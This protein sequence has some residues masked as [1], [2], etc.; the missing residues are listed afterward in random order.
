[1]G[2]PEPATLPV[3]IRV[4]PEPQ[5]REEKK[6]RRA[7]LGRWSIPT[8]W[9]VVDTETRIDA[10][11]RLTFGSYRFLVDGACL[12]EG[13]FYADDLPQ[14]DR[15][16]LEHYVRTHPADTVRTGVPELKLLSRRE[17]LRKFYKAAY[18][19]RC[20]VIGFNL[21]FDVSR[22][23]FAVSDARRRFTGGFSLSL[24]D[25]RGADG[26]ATIFRP[27]IDIKQIDSKR[28]L[29]GFTSHA[30]VEDDDRI[31]EGSASGKPVKDYVFRGNFLDLRTLAFA[32]TDR[33]HSLESACETFGVEH[34][35]VKAAQHGVVTPDYIDYNRRDVLATAE[36]ADKLIRE[37]ERHPIDLQVTKA[38]SAA[39]IGKA[40]LRAMGIA[41]V[42]ERQPHF[43]KRY[44]GFAQTA[45]FGG[46]ASAHIR[47]VPVPVVYVDF[48]SMY[49]TVNSLMRLG[50]M[51]T[52]PKVRVRECAAE[53]TEFLA[54][55]SKERLFVPKTWTELSA[56][57]RIVTDGDIL[58]TRS[59]YSRKSN[60]W[61]V[62]VN[63][64][65]ARDDSP[66][67]WFALPDLVASVLLTGRV[68]KIVEAFRIE[69]EGTL[70]TLRPIQFRGMV[71]IDPRQQDFFKTI[72]EERKR[73][74]RRK[75][76]PKLERD[77]L[78]KAAK[79]TGSAT[80]YG[81]FAQM[82]RHEESQKV[83]VT[84]YGLDPE[85][86]TCSV[87]HPES[88]GDFCFPPV[89]S[90]IT[91]GARLMLA[92]LER[93][94]RDLGGT[95]AMEDTDSMAIVASE[96]GGLVPCPGGPFCLDDGREAIKALRWSDVS[97]IAKQFRKLNPYDRK[98]VRGS[99]LKIEDDNF[100]PVTGKQRQV[101]CLA[102]SAKRY[103][104]FLRDDK[105]EPQLLR[106]GLN[107]AEDRWS[108][109]GLGHL[110]NPTDPESEDREWIAK[111]WLAIVRRAL[112]L[113]TKPLGFES[114]PAVGRISVSSPHVREALKTLNGGRPYS[115][116]IK[117]FNF[118]L[119]CH[120]K[121]LGHPI[122]VDPERFH[123]IG[124]YD[125][126]PKN[127]LKSKWIDQYSNPPRTYRITTASRYGMR[128]IARV[129]TYGDVLREYEYHA[130]AKYAAPNGLPSTKQTIG[131]LQRRHVRVG[132]I[133]PI[134]KESNSLE[135]VEAGHEHD[136]AKVYTEYP[137][138]RYDHWEMAVLPAMKQASLKDLVA[139]TGRS[140][141]MLKAARAGR[142]PHPKNMRLV[143]EALRRLHLL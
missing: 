124:P 121:A 104:L 139:E 110:L 29:I 140:P 119:S 115:E 92:L 116:Q 46:R 9:F 53:V 11:Q 31:P 114:R 130:E 117:P 71:T 127:W 123:L 44:L 27:R 49:T 109:H 12:E 141:A 87:K 100:D 24:W 26:R 60:D 97:A 15:R 19:G 51:V 88:P 63:H 94:V 64:L 20:L 36:L 70:D 48:V 28:S 83:P 105:G 66:D 4:Y 18:R 137:D 5:L 133:T 69:P 22:L 21:P 3:A 99:I 42:L 112:G 106:R 37:Y 125:P 78:D 33:G 128:G 134:G 107:N 76:L 25:R 8:A 61:Q 90:L 68:P 122:G 43:P 40:Y 62:A 118:L 2:A 101:W 85:P 93:S 74:A 136:P 23:A 52:V 45:F 143:A 57:A 120:V 79:T 113:P 47:K 103:A 17:F 102:I 108:E 38:Y 67:L 6:E 77:R 50:G 96:G 142:R 95:F 30:A 1:M 32:L 56:F 98:A 91:A 82:D 55:V 84:C 80:S 59:K 135:D 72:I 54:R 138:P 65:H 126:N 10:T 131:L 13:L 132:Q 129:K 75:D 41:P 81:I 39:S 89:A 35:K 111:A 14:D 7:R 58:P 73:S 86:Y 34:G 16:V